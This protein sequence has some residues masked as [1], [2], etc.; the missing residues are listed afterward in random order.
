MDLEDEAAVTV[1]EAGVELGV[2]EKRKKRNGSL[3]QSLE[4]LYNRS[5]LLSTS[6]CQTSRSCEGTA[7]EI[8]QR[9]FK[10]MKPYCLLRQKWEIRIRQESL[11]EHLVSH[12]S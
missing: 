1:A 6:T 9:N 12:Q 11:I 3:A 2:T 10:Y 5:A 4:D 7:L 8:I